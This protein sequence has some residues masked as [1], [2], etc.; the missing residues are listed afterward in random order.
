MHQKQ[1]NI[2]ERKAANRLRSLG[3][4]VIELNWK[5]PTAEIDIIATKGRRNSKQI[6]FFEVKYRKNPMQGSGF[7]YITPVKL[8]QMSYAANLYLSLNSISYQPRLGAIEVS[9]VDYSEISI[10]TNLS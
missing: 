6:L 2:A 5:V 4:K 10:L 9:K 3:Y 7:S 8:N 1:G